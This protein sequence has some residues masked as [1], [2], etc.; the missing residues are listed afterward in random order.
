MSFAKI[1]INGQAGDAFQCWDDAPHPGVF[2]SFRVLAVDGGVRVL[3]LSLHYERLLLGCQRFGLTAPSL[4]YITSEIRTCMEDLHLKEARVRVEIFRD[5]F[6]TRVAAIDPLQ[7]VASSMKLQTISVSRPYEDLKSSL[8]AALSE[9]YQSDCQPS[10]EMLYVDPNGFII[11]GA[12]SNFGWIDSA[13]SVC[14]TGRGLNGVTQRVIGALLIEE[15]RSVRIESATLHDLITGGVA[16]FI[17]SA[18]R[19][20][21]AVSKINEAFFFPDKDIAKIR[22]RYMAATY[23]LLL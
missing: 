8:G 7:Q 18:L 5:Q 13:G 1:I 19:G 14:F 16:P 11:E 15:G 3:G 21:I 10:C 23:A 12:W 9:Q 20:I 6:I 2:T 22:E 4:H 17:M